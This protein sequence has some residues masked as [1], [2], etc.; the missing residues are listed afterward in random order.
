MNRKKVIYISILL[1]LTVILSITYFSY[2]FFTRQDILDGKLNIVTGTLKYKITS[3]D[4]DS[5]NTITLTANEKK[6]FNISVKSLNDINSKYIL[7][8]QTQNS[9]FNIGYSSTTVDATSGV[10]DAN[11]TKNITISLQN[12]NSS[13]ITITFGVVGG[14]TSNDLVLDTG[15]AI[16]TQFDYST[17]NYNINYAWDFPFYGQDDGSSSVQTFTV[18]CDGKYRVELWGAT[19]DKGYSQDG[20]AA[21]VAGDIILSKPLSLS[22]YVGGQGKGKVG[23][24]NGGGTGSQGYPYTAG[25][26]ATDVRIGG[27][28]LINRVIVAAGSGGGIGY[29]GTA[30]SQYC[31]DG[32][33]LNGLINR[34]RKNSNFLDG[35]GASQTAGG[36][37]GPGGTHSNGAT[38]GSFG[39][40]GTGG[41]WGGGAGGGGYYG[42]GGGSHYTPSDSGTG[43]GGSSYISG[44]TGCVAVTSSGTA[45]SGC[46]TGTSDR[47]CSIHYLNYSFTNTNMIDGLGHTWTNVDIGID[48]NNLMPNPT[49]G[50]YASGV[51]HS[52]R[53]YARITYLGE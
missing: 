42:G 31:G 13:S 39:Q 51:G 45:K 22:I 36:A 2:A 52:G 26:G 3:S 50:Y 32:G 15:I 25:G 20:R 11:A 14:F 6:K 34:T 16:N 8:Y 46:A 48:N 19:G 23:G 9:N 7:Y 41:Y 53:G 18:P 10:I 43:G 5:N 29:A 44:H 12:N 47:N 30:S 37:L 21:Y 27:T 28:A 17:C 24:Y 38:A 33:G 49:G 35:K 40:G 1:I 4:L